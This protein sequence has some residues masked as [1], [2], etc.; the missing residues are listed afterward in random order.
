MNWKVRHRLPLAGVA[1]TSTAF[2]AGAFECGWVVLSPDD[3]G[4]TRCPHALSFRTTISLSRHGIF[5]LL[6]RVLKPDAAAIA[7][8]QPAAKRTALTAALAAAITAAVASASLATAAAATLAAAITTAA[9]AGWPTAGMCAV[10]HSLRVRRRWRQ[11]C[12]RAERLLVVTPSG[13]A[14]VQAHGFLRRGVHL[15]RT[16]AT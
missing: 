8:S 11:D 9:A 2:L 13:D 1:V 10:R 6:L 3:L 14:A 15:V 12:N 16:R 5:I 7:A 4:L